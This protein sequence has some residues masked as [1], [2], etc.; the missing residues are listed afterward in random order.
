[1]SKLIYYQLTDDFTSN[2]SLNYFLS[3]FDALHHSGQCQLQILRT[4]PVI[5][6]HAASRVFLPQRPAFVG[7]Y[8][9]MDECRDLFFCI[10]RSDHASNEMDEGYDLALLREV[11]Y[12]FKV[13]YRPDIVAADPELAPFAH[14]ILPL[15]PGF[16][17]R[18]PAALGWRGGREAHDSLA[19]DFVRLRR[20]LRHSRDV[21]TLAQ[22]LRLRRIR[23]DFDVVF[24]TSLYRR[25]HH[26]PLNDLRY[27]IIEGLR[28]AKDLKVLAGFASPDPLP[29]PY[30]RFRIARQSMK[31]YL[32]MIAR[33]RIALYVRGAH[34]CLSAKLGYHL[35]LGQPIV[36]QPL[37]PNPGLYRCDRFDEQ[38]AFETPAEILEGILALRDDPAACDALAHSNLRTFDEYFAPRAVAAQI[39]RHIQ[40]PEV[41]SESA[42]D[43]TALEVSFLQ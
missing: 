23:P 6:N 15:P 10:D 8:R 3:G 30:E 20:W 9:Y 38:F 28:N 1:M 24:V 26:R 21:P 37:Y 5:E 36:G 19:T 14:K 43:G 34:D 2:H 40:E 16:L 18:T 42:A 7:L 27:E 25:P 4:K 41:E 12:Y 31:N 22:V 32:Q 39:L 13:N 33:S 11:R 29:E 17:V 35:A